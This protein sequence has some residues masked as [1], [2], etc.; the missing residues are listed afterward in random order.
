[1][2]KCHTVS[3]EHN[4]SI[5]SAN[6]PDRAGQTLENIGERSL[7]AS[8]VEILCHNL[9]HSDLV[10]SIN[11]PAMSHQS[12]SIIARPGF[13]HYR[14]V[15]GRVVHRIINGGELSKVPTSVYPKC[16]RQK[17][18]AFGKSCISKAPVE[19]CVS[20]RS[21]WHTIEGRLQS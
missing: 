10:L 6:N 20:R 11:D 13:S 14:E 4:V 1:M 18:C 12:G 2:E 17:G 21:H 5:L 19:G 16:S 9:S 8:G 3:Q 7:H 15:T